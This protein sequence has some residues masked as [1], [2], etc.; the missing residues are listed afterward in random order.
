MRAKGQVSNGMGGRE[1]NAGPGGSE[2]SYIDCELARRLGQF[3]RG[4]AMP[5]SVLQAVE[6]GEARIIHAA[7]QAERSTVD[8][9]VVGVEHSVSAAEALPRKSRGQPMRPGRH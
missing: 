1:F 8:H 3:G 5:E 4:L 9:V 7:G 6:A 2:H